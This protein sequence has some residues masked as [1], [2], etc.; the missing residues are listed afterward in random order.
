MLHTSYAI[1]GI[2]II[3]LLAVTW[4]VKRSIRRIRRGGRVDGLDPRGDVAMSPSE[5]E[6]RALMFLMTRKTDAVLAALART[7]EEERQKLG[8]VVRNPSMRAAL[9]AA[10]ASDPSAVSRTP[11]IADRILPLIRQGMTEAAIARSLH[12]PEAE[13]T[14]VKRLHAA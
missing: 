3:T 5:I 1:W 4:M 6:H 8:G 9:D 2:V 7:I 11:S 12:V 10:G 13:V 14:M